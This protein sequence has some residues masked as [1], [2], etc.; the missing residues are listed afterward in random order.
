MGYSYR[1]VLLYNIFN[2]L[3]YTRTTPGMMPACG[4]M[5]GVY[6]K[7][8]SKC[9]APGM[10][11]PSKVLAPIPKLGA[12]FVEG[13]PVTAQPSRNAFDQ[14]TPVGGNTDRDAI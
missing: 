1:E 7:T 14:S 2:M 13:S 4:L 8:A 11:P 12:P 5:P 10:P 6:I 3:L 9:N